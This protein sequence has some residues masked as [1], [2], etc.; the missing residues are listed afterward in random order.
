MNLLRNAVGFIF[1]VAILLPII[2]YFPITFLIAL[3]QVENAKDWE[4]TRCIAR[5]DTSK[6]KAFVGYTY[7][8][9]IN[10]G[11][12]SRL[13]RPKMPSSIDSLTIEPLKPEPNL[14]K[15]ERSKKFKEYFERKKRQMFERQEKMREDQ[16]LYD[17]QIQ[18]FEREEQKYMSEGTEYFSIFQIDGWRYWR[19]YGWSEICHDEFGNRRKPRFEVDCYID[20]AN[21][22]KAV[23]YRKLELNW[24]LTMLL[25]V[26]FLLMFGFLWLAVYLFIYD[27]RRGKA[28]A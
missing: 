10:Y 28:S 8:F 18:I 12:K 13:E 24:I 14:S 23:F 17:Q 15:D 5:C 1:F 6:T 3:W 9:W 4:T 11:F 2:G 19:N 16:K 26:N 27:M 25:T 7:K 20:P 21:P 22:E